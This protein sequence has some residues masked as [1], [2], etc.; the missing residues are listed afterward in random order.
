MDGDAVVVEYSDHTTAVYTEDQLATIKP[1]HVV[2][3][4]DERK[5]DERGW[6]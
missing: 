3:T 2:V 6:G 1:K 5:E 4:Q